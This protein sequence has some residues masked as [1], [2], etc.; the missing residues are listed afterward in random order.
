MSS[1][2]VYQIETNDQPSERKWKGKLKE[3]R[4][5]KNISASDL[6]IILLKAEKRAREGKETVFFHGET[7][8]TGER[9]EQFKRRRTVK[10]SGIVYPNA[11]TCHSA[12]RIS[13]SGLNYGEDTPKNI[14]YHTPRTDSP[15]LTLE[16]IDE[17][18]LPALENNG[19]ATPECIFPSMTETPRSFVQKSGNMNSKH[20]S[21]QQELL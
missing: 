8:I 3:W 13:G 19:L 20:P 6:G 11:S 21:L 18:D 2:S 17:K 16:R 5:D 15:E 4:F 9:I 14:T 7:L 12:E 1:R 10:E